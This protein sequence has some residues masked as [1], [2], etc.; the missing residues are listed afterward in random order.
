MARAQDIVSRSLVKNNKIAQSVLE[1]FAARFE[2]SRRNFAALTEADKGIEFELKIFVS[3]FLFV[4]F[5]LQ[6]QFFIFILL[7]FV[8]LSS[9]PI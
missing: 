3:I 7:G 1:R 9:D 8:L 4:F 2:L 6:N 5:F